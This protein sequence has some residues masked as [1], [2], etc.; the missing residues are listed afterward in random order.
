[1]LKEGDSIMTNKTKGLRLNVK[2]QLVL[3]NAIIVVAILFVATVVQLGIASSVTDKVKKSTEKSINEKL[4]KAAE[5]SSNI[6]KQKQESL[7]KESGLLANSED[8]IALIRYGAIKKGT[9]YEKG[10]EEGEVVR[11]YTQA[12]GRL[13]YITLVNNLKRNMYKNDA[14]EHIEL[15]DATGEVKANTSQ[16]PDSFKEQS[17]SEI[18]TTILKDSSAIT[19]ANIVNTDE[20]LAIKAYTPVDATFIGADKP[21][22]VIVTL[23]LNKIFANDLK[24]LSGAD[25]AIYNRDKFMTGTLFNDASEEIILDT[26]EKDQKATSEVFEKLAAEDKIV[27]K[28]KKVITGQKN[29]KNIEK[30]YRF[31][32]TPIH[33]SKGEAVGMVAVGVDADEVTKA[34]ADVEN[35]QKATLVIIIMVSAIGVLVGI[36]FIYIYAGTLT[37]PLKEVLKAV[38]KIAEGDLTQKVFINRKDEIG[39]LAKGINDM[40][41]NLRLMVFQITDMSEKIASSTSQISS[42]SESHKQTMEEIAAVA[43][44]IKEKASTEKDK[45]K[46]GGDFI[47]QIIAGVKEISRYSESV[48]I[49]SSESSELAK[50]GGKSVENA[51]RSISSIKNTVEDT[52][53][54]VN[55]LREKTEVI[56]K[57]VSVIT[58]IAD[59]TNLLALN[60]AIEAAR[61]GEVGKGFAVVANEVKKL[62]NQSAEAAEEI[63]KIILGIQEEANN[64]NVSMVKGIEEVEK[65]VSISKTAGEALQK[66]IKSVYETTEMVTEITAS[67][68]EQSASSE[69]AIK[70]ME[71]L[72]KASE[73][74]NSISDKIYEEAQIQLEGLKE[75]VDGVNTLLEAAETL[76]SMIDVFK[77]GDNFDMSKEFEEELKGI[78]EAGG[79]G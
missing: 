68:Q 43:R 45:V 64:V 36:V 13:Q 60:A 65:G 69:E 27:I 52:A 40:S 59:Q 31:A 4:R 28:D 63:R 51:I 16:F 5:I 71:E 14:L 73:E 33:N 15:V 30:T 17:N 50:T 38:N 58:G 61:A 6:V 78:R 66:I 29:G 47:G 75:I 34:I 1:M 62:A 3:I 2:Q 11:R 32:Y 12:S 26:D 77:I 76:N 67:T 22:V 70:V 23:P 18:I 24:N 48:T 25:I 72:A 56:D 9:E 55:S 19:I 79:N 20:G 41:N 35:S 21:G 39:D 53:K 46:D 49:K 8:T 44:A 7:L 54:I 37:K 74:T 42:T 57:V 10:K